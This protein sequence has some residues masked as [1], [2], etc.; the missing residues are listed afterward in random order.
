MAVRCDVIAGVM[1]LCATRLRRCLQC[2]EM[3]YEGRDGGVY[4]LKAVT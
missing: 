3:R 2:N 4:V 1:W